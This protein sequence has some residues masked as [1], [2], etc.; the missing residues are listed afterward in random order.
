MALDMFLLKK[1]V[2][3]KNQSPILRFYSWKGVWLSIGRNQKNIPKHWK[4]LAHEK[5]INLVRRPSGGDAVL[6]GNNL[7]YSLIWPTPPRRKHEAYIK[8]SEWLIKGFL[9]LG[10]SLHFGNQ[11][12]KPRESNCFATSSAAD[13]VDKSGQKRIGNAQRWLKGQVLQHG[14]ILLNP[15]MKLWEEIFHS[16]VPLN[17]K[18]P[19]QR[20]ILE[21]KLLGALKS[22]WSNISWSTD[23]LTDMEFDVIRAEASNYEVSLNL[24]GNSIIRDANIASTT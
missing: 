5:K 22:E 12:I 11:S 23:N 21:Q 6:H 4:K 19:I 17:T 9:E 18:M 1:S 7:T 20:K 3:T 13:L 10:I 14:E 8:I 24:S 2:C 15:H 16:P